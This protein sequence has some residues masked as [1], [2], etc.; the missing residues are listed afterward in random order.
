MRDESY[1]AGYRA[2]HLQGWL[3]AM[4]KMGAT[5]QAVSPSSPGTPPPA[6]NAASAEP[7]AAYNF[8]SVATPGP[9]AELPLPLAAGVPTRLAEASHPVLAAAGAARPAA[10]SHVDHAVPPFSSP[11]AFQPEETPAEQQA[12]HEK[13]DRQ[14]I[15]ITLYVASLLLVAAAALFI[16]TSLPPMLRFAGVCVVTAAF[17]AAGFVLHTR[18]PRL[19]PA[20][21]AFAGTGLALVPVTGLALYNF[22]LHHGPTAWLITSLIGTAAYVAAAVRLESRVLV[23]LSL[24]FVASTA[25]SGVSV[26]GGALVWYFAALICVAVLLTLLA[27]AK[28]GWLPPVYARPLMVL[29]PLVVPAVAAAATCVPLLLDKTE[30]ALVM[31]MCGCYFGLMAA[32]PG[33]RLRLVNFYAA[34]ISLTL[35]AAVEVWHLTGR[36]SDA[37]LAAAAVLAVQGVAV[38]LAAARLGHWYPEAERP[39]DQAETAAGTMRSR[40]PVDAL[41]TFSI[42]LLAT[43]VYASLVLAAEFYRYGTLG[44]VGDVPLWMP[45]A[46]AMATGFVL[47]ARLSGPVEWAPVASLLLVGVLGHAMGAWAVAIML[48]LAFLFWAVRAFFAAG[49]LRRNLALGARVA[50]T[51]AVPFTVA[52]MLDA[53]PDRVTVSVFALLVALVCQ[54]LF[55]AVL[56][57]YGA[58]SLAP[59]AT[60]AGFG[61]AGLATVVLLV[62]LDATPGHGW[63]QAAVFIQLLAAILIGLLAVPRPASASEWT[64]TV[65][66]A[67]PLATSM[68]CV[69]VSFLAV[70][71]AAGDVA[72]LLVLGYLAASG[73]RLRARQHRWTYWWLGRLAATVLVLTAFDL[74]QREAG[75]TVIGVDELRPVTVLVLFLAIQLVFPVTAVVRGKAPRGVLADPG[76]V[77]L[78]QLMAS[79]ALLAVDVDGWQ[80]PFAA[81]VTAI[82]AVA[83]GYAFRARGAA[84][85]FA[86]SSLVILLA[87]SGGDLLVIELVL[88][89]FAVFAALMVVASGEPVRKGWYFAGARLLTAALAAV[90]S[91]DATASPTA[92]SVTFA[93]V[94]AAQ[95]GVRWLMRSRLAEVPFQ[96]AAVWITLAGQALLPF[97]YAWQAQSGWGRIPDDDGGRWVVLLELVLLSSSAVVASRFFAA[98]GSLYFGIYALLFG[99]LSLGPV[100][101]FANG[102]QPDS[103]PFLA[104]PV[105]DHTGTAAVLLLA[106]MV[107]SVAG[108][109][110]QGRNVAVTDVDHWLWLGA[111]GPFAVTAI[112]V[113]PMASDW[114]AGAALLVVAGVCFTASHV[115]GL[116]WL[117]APAALAALAGGTQ[118][119]DAAFR[120]VPGEWGQYLPWLCGA[121]L[122]AAGLYGARLYRSEQLAADP[123]RRW[124]LSGAAFLGLCIV[125]LTGVRPDATSW[126]AAVA[127]AAAVG[128]ACLEAPGTARRVVAE[129]GFVVVVAAVQRAAIFELDGQFGLDYSLSF[130]L[131]DP[132]WVAQWYVLAG[133][134]L[135]TLRFAT[136]QRTAGRLLLGAAAGLLT[137]SG[138]GV[139]FGGT[140]GQQ[141]WVLVLF[142]G[143]MLAGLG[144]GERLFVWWGAAGVAGCILWAMRQYTFALLALIAVGL[145]VFAVWRLNRGTAVEKPAVQPSPGQPSP[146]RPDG[147]EPFSKH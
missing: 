102:S 112:L 97:V 30:Y 128:V 103:A 122:S 137:L 4:A 8:A 18:V 119:A 144:L 53:H 118:L 90:L 76:V 27:L 5:R 138:L 139:V 132:F 78:F 60:V 83:S 50:M 6:G 41:A 129:A 31:A 125:A 111:A 74:F 110:R 34:R 22:A 17:Y 36:G 131:P 33:S 70:S 1:E 84:V 32:V 65:W 106:A 114:V 38:A 117:Y 93:F 80:A 124:S 21:V 58:G 39:H 89:I 94:L 63:I 120:D 113:A 96:Q 73:L 79:A 133:A 107:A 7:A 46:M 105:L 66:E 11:A 136:G 123:V 40:W 92:V 24:T 71:Q 48:A 10:G 9:V 135:G 59:E 99:V 85:W 29:H 145:I 75:P 52:A 98:R 126:A 116:P 121:G 3:D 62:L 49:A 19:R 23:Y 81:A 61:V 26:L 146:D 127:V 147:G 47:A 141:L 142:A 37:F 2:G 54:Q 87:F 95:H 143:L 13:R 25:W 14:N 15:N 108:V 130:G 68:L 12:R 72:L 43:L 101:S 42:Q 86:P 28:P 56:Q 69:P 115:E 82:C 44:Q 45:V 67:L 16:G 140:G 109:L 91:Y 20:A 35:A 104:A 100:V 134:G 55:S 88:G 64:P 57:R 77:L 51:L